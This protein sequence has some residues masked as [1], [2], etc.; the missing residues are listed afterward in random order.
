[1]SFASQYGITITQFITWSSVLNSLCS[2]FEVV[3]GHQICVSYPGSAPSEANSYASAKFGA[4]ASVAASVPTDVVTGTNVNC[5]KYYRVKGTP[6][7]FI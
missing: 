4:T 2:N 6:S 1:M 7:Y 5:G 3:V